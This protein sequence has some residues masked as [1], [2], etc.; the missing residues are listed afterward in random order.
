MSKDRVAKER[1]MIVEA[2]EKGTGATILT[3]GKLSGPG[4]LQS[5]L[6]LGGGSLASSLYLGVLA[7]YSM[8]WLQP[9]AM[10][11]GI[12]MLSAISYVTLSTGERPF[13]AINRHISPIAGWGWL[14][15]S[16]AANMVWALPQ[17][18]LCYGVLEKNLMPGVLG[19]GGSLA[20]TT[21]K[22]VVSLT[23]LTLSTIV[24]WSYGSGG[25]G[26]KVYEWVLKIVV[27]LIVACFVGVVV[28][29][30]FSEDGLAWGEIFRGFIPS[31]RQL[32]EPADG[33][34]VAI[35]TIPNEAAREYWTNYVVAEQRDVMLSAAAT[36]VGI[37][38][39]FL[40]PYSL[41]S[42]GWDRDFRGLATFDL[43]TGMFIPFVLA[44]SAVVIASAS[45]FHVQVPEGAVFDEA[46]GHA[47]AES[48][49]LKAEIAKAMDI[50]DAKV[51]ANHSHAEEYVA[52]MLVK[53]NAQSL[54][55]SLE[56]LMGKKW[57]N[58]VFGLGVVAMAMS[59]ISLL[60]LISGFVVCE[61]MDVPQKGWPH[62][63]GCMLAATGILWP[64]VWTGDARFWLAIIT[65]LFGIMLLP[66]A[67]ITFYLMMNKDSMLGKDR[68]RGFAA[69]RW[70]VGMGIAALAATG[71]SLYVIY[72][73]FGQLLGK[74]TGYFS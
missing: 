72:T 57:A 20:G 48:P 44:T 64:M 21:G 22:W 46:H 74:I 56:P 34:Q 66:I 65:S 42:R 13:R 12:I 33:F 19:E 69:V 29:M 68:P 70:N 60:M 41:L 31:F 14:L 55:T 28:A 37:N 38:M 4:W 26:V 7:G 3:Y 8:M 24:V 35:R 40:L 63:L 51:E 30:T 49:A 45:Q 43:S 16:L 39:T 32:F 73:K 18:S 9:I 61:I 62:R 67:Y 5:A 58:W 11:L 1:Q 2:R 54:A 27:G 50:R 10:I 17:Y 15:A 25:W 59:T 52:M 36:A 71:A 23:V 6:T 53:R 47:H